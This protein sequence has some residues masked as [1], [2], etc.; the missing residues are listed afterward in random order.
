MKAKKRK[1]TKSK[2]ILRA[3]QVSKGFTRSDV[4]EKLK[5]SEP[6]VTQYWNNPGKM[7]ATMRK[8]VAAILKIDISIM[9][10]IANG[11]IT[12]INQLINA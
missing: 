9:D 3:L 7:D 10:D 2:S 1:Y 8:N 12:D 11:T 6:T 4:A 5:V